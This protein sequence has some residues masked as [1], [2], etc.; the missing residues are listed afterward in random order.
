MKLE[1]D[2]SFMNNKKN[3]EPKIE[4]WR[5]PEII[6]SKDDLVFSLLNVQEFG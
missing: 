2:K 3:K 1:L 4:P 5:S 6:D